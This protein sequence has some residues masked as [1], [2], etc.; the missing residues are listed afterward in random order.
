MLFTV[1]FITRVPELVTSYGGSPHGECVAAFIINVRCFI[2]VEPTE[3]TVSFAVCC[4]EL[5]KND[6]YGHNYRSLCSRC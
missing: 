3:A 4:A 1:Y 6:R 5:L 2:T